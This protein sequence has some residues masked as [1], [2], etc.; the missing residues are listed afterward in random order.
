MR[1]ESSTFELRE[2]ASGVAIAASV[3]EVSD[4]SC[5]SDRSVKA[6]Q[7]PPARIPCSRTLLGAK[8]P[9]PAR[10]SAWVPMRACN[11]C[12]ARLIPRSWLQERCCERRGYVIGGGRLLSVLSRW[13]DL[14]KPGSIEVISALLGRG[15]DRRW[16]FGAS[17][18][19]KVR[20]RRAGFP[21]HRASPRLD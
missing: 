12:T 18:R 1:P 5:R 4:S 11:R 13:R 2:L 21:H 16:G 20:W 15:A 14:L 9:W 10:P 3:S 19:S 6:S 17:Y 8:Q 7:R